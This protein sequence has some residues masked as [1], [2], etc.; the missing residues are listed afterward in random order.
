MEHLQHHIDLDEGFFKAF[1]EVGRQTFASLDSLRM[2]NC[3]R[4]DLVREYLDEVYIGFN[5][6][7][8]EY[9]F[10]VQEVEIGREPRKVIAIDTSSIKIAESARG[11][12]ISVKGAIVI[13]DLDKSTIVKTVGPFIFYITRKNSKKVFGEYSELLKSTNRYDFYLYAQKILTELLEKRLQEYTVEKY[14]D[15]I[16]L[17][18]GSL[19]TTTFNCFLDSIEKILKKTLENKNEILAFSKTSFLQ[20]S[21]E[22][23]QIIHSEKNPPYIIDLTKALE[24][25]NLGRIRVYGRVYLARLVEGSLGYRVDAYLQ[26]EASTVFGLLLK[27]DPLIYGYPE[28]LI[29]AHDYSTFTKLDTITLQ[30]MLKKMN[31]E[32]LYPESVRDI[33]FNPLDGG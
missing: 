29:L 23:L 7:L 8:D 16:I 12:V 24:Y 4:E 32:L 14:K 25:S 13:R 2:Y 9:F 21:G 28:T 27:N 31:V 20:I 22:P 3:S 19:T 15:S 26:N 5:S 30:T 18:D 11:V 10:E 6:T 17:F 33:L 1:S